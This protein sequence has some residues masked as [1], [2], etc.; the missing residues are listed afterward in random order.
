M[1][2]IA[3]HSVPRSGSTWL[4]NI[5]NS[6]SKVT[7]K[8]QPLFSYAFKGAISPSATKED[9][10]SF[11]KKIQTSEDSFIN[12][13]EGIEKGIIPVFRKDENP[14]HICYKEVRYH[15]VLENMLAKN[16]EFK[17]I[18]LIRNPLAV[19]YSWYNAPKEFR[20]EKGWV[21][22]EEWLNAAKK[23]LNKPE[24]YNGYEKWKEATRL[25]LELKKHYSNRVCIINYSELLADTTNIIKELFV[26]SNLEFTKD[27]EEFIAKS[28]S[29]NH[30]NAYSV[31]KKKT[32]DNN[33][34]ELPSHIIDYIQKDLKDTELEVFLKEYSV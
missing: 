30:E 12:Q 13:T 7:F 17:L 32:K 24:E 29:V 14:T 10:N 23:N 28:T 19:L 25:F 18:L 1:N 21:F 20:K 33:W 9:I 22:D 5:F 26:F 11:F 34:H 3:I 31:Y 2:K 16:D 27:T 8:L 15:H 4:G 6:H